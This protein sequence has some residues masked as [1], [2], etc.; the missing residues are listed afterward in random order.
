[1]KRNHASMNTRRLRSWNTS[2]LRMPSE[3]QTSI[4]DKIEENKI[5]EVA[6]A[7]EADDFIEDYILNQAYTSN[8]QSSVENDESV[9]SEDIGKI[10]LDPENADELAV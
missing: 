5:Y 7:E 6:E 4:Q 8:N 10:Y 3:I 9:S 2:W 1:M